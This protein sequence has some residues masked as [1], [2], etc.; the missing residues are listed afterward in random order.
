MKP[1]N[2]GGNLYDPQSWNKYSYV[3]NN[4]I[5]FND[6]TGHMTG[7]P[8]SWMR[9]GIP[10]PP[11]G[12]G[13]PEEGG[14]WGTQDGDVT[15]SGSPDDPFVGPPITVRPPMTEMQ[16]WGMWALLHPGGGGGGGG[17]QA[18]PNIRA[19]WGAWWGNFKAGTYWGTE[20]GEDALEGYGDTLADPDAAWYEKAWAG[21][22]GFFS[23][24]WTPGTYIY[25]TGTL[26][27]GAAVA[28]W[29]AQTGPIVGLKGG[30]VTLTSQGANKPF[31]R[32]NPTGNWKASNPLSRRPHYHR[33]PI[34][35]PAGPG[36][37][38][39]RHRPWEG[40]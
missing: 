8:G 13:A 7:I 5:N 31:L 4:P 3:N 26:M 34:S 24:L 20:A 12:T 23:A 22:G 2:I 39:G 19:N 29:A 17:S 32:I 9:G 21:T 1:D 11:I 27:G 25:T 15:G 38:I 16:R 37:G 35:R 6:P 28:P 30:E 14:E 10:P 36:E 18:E 33:R 40:W